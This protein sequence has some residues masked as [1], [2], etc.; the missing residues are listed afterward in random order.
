[1]TRSPTFARHRVSKTR[2]RKVATPSLTVVPEMTLNAGEP[3]SFFLKENQA[4]G[5]G[6][7]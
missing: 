4:I 5:G 6:R 3:L 2:G 7:R 1:M